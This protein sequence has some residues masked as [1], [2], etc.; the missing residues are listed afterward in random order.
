MTPAGQDLAS[1]QSRRRS[2]CRAET[3]P[4]LDVRDL[5]VHFPVRRGLLQRVVGTVKAVDGISFSVYQGQTL[6]LVGESG[7]GKTTTGRAL[8]RLIQP[9]SGDSPLSGHGSRPLEQSSTAN[10]A[11]SVADHLSGPLRFSESPHDRRDGID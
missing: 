4:L 7:C 9:T 3:E 11:P 5:K 8:L 10:Y 1:R 2:S 6:G